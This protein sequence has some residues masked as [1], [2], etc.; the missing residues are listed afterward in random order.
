MAGNPGV[1]SNFDPD[2]TSDMFGL[3]S[4]GAYYPLDGSG[5]QAGLISTFS[6]TIDVGSIPFAQDLMIGLVN[7][8]FTNTFDSL[9]F[10]VSGF[11]T[12]VDLTFT[13]AASALSYFNDNTLNLGSLAGLTGSL[14]LNFEFDYFAHIQGAG[15][16]T[17]LAFGNT[18]F[19]SGPPVPVPSAVLLLGS[20]LL[21]L[22]TYRR[23]LSRN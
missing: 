6:Q 20:G 11:G 14:T 13:D 7:P 10:I 4:M 23:R 21:G 18:T 16:S 15:F 5:V 3:A 9:R 12:G 1:R 8:T 19:G 17:Q 22:A 2:G